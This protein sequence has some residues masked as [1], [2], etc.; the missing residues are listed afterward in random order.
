M[1]LSQVAVKIFKG[2]HKILMHIGHAS[3]GEAVMY[4]P[5]ECYCLVFH[6]C[7]VRHYLPGILGWHEHHGT[8]NGEG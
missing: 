8:D 6:C 5:L 2:F 7:R 4:S 1:H 3:V